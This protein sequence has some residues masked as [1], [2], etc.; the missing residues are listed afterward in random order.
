[1]PQSQKLKGEVERWTCERHQHTY[2]S[3]EA[4]GELEPR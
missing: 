2:G 4:L 1:M 3:D